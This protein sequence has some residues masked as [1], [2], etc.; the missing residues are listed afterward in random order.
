MYRYHRIDTPIP[1]LY[2]SLAC[3]TPQDDKV[4]R[5]SNHTLELGYPRAI[6]E[7]F[8]GVPSHLDAAVECPKGE[9]SENAVLFFKGTAWVNTAPSWRDNAPR[10]WG[11]GPHP[12]GNLPTQSESFH[13]HLGVS[14]TG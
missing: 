4:F 1:T 7:V 6:Q 10:G 9:C 5:Y 12:L 13:N 2:I 3:P 11:L 8:P 14:Y